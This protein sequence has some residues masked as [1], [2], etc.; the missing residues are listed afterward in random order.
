[1]S[2]DAAASIDRYDALLGKTA[3]CTLDARLGANL[4]SPC[5]CELDPDVNPPAPAHFISS[6]EAAQLSRRSC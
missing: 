5:P 2:A 4:A 6:R 3:K 1:M